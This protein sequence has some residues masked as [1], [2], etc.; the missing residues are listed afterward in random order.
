[1]KGDIKVTHN[2]GQG[3]KPLLDLWDSENF[4]ELDNLD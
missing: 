3:G 4:L 2:T 1:M